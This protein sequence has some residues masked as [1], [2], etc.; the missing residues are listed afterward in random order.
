MPDEFDALN[1]AGLSDFT[2]VQYTAGED[3]LVIEASRDLAYYVDAEIRFVNVEYIAL[4][5]YFYDA[6]FRAATD[7]ETSEL[8]RL[9]E[10]TDDRRVFCI[11]EDADWPGH[12]RRYFVVATSASVNMEHRARVRS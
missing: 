7:A 3:L 1:A 9:T 8:R 11:V 2:V 6:A 10:W 5:T 4:P 12:E